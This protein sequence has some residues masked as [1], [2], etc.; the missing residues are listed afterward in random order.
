M[1]EVCDCAE[2]F[3]GFVIVDEIDYKERVHWDAAEGTR[4]SPEPDDWHKMQTFSDRVDG[5]G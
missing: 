3:S 4:V 5:G 2:E 1:S